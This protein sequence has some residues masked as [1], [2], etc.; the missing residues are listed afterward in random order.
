MMARCRLLLFPHFVQLAVNLPTGAD[1]RKQHGTDLRDPHGKPGV[2]KAKDDFQQRKAGQQQDD[3][4]DGC[5]NH[6]DR[7]VA[8]T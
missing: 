1:D 5:A 7:S 2:W 8:K 4:P 3:L 6:V